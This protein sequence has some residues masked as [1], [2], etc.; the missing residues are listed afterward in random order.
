VNAEVGISQKGEEKPPWNVLTGKIN[1]GLVKGD[2][3]WPLKLDDSSL[4][5]QTGLLL[6]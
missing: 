6:L 5:D 3:I 1:T 2:P 4:G